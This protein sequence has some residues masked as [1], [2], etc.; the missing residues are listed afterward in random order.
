MMRSW[1]WDLHGNVCAPARL[2]V[3]FQSAL[4]GSDTF[5]HVD[6]TQ[7]QMVR[8]GPIKIEP[9]AAVVNRQR[10]LLSVAGQFE[11]DA[12]GSG[13]LRHVRQAFLRNPVEARCG[14]S[15]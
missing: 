3:D 9:D 5:T 11:F 8:P 6:E 12:G 7:T 4:D 2:G 1:E 14:V 13:M 10:N 15:R